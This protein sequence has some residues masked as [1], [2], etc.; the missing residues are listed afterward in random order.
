[1]FAAM[2]SKQPA[3][4]NGRVVLMHRMA[5][6]AGVLRGAFLETDYASFVAW[7]RWGREAVGIYDCFGAA[8]VQTADGAFL[9]GVM[10]AHTYNAGQLYFPCGTPDK[11]DITAD[12][13]VDFDFS[14]RRELREETGIDAAALTAEPGYTLVIDGTL[15]C[16][17]KVMR[18]KLAAEP[19]R[20]QI[21]DTI[22]REAQ[23]ELADIRIMRS[24]A[25][26]DPMMRGFARA[27]LEHRF[28]KAREAR[29]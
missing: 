25:D 23:P 29:S 16:V 11:S 5:I 12:A 8:A 4:F 21:L 1:M 15:I 19:L 3:L 28:Q 9:L 18:S 2:K 14:I 27:F 17:A 20:A 6:E 7:Q 22:R 26:F 10:G 24:A 13:K